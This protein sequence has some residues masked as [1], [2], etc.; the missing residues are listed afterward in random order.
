MRDPWSILGIPKGSSQEEIKKTYRKLARKWHPD[1]NKDPLA[2]E[3]FKEINGAYTRL[4]DSVEE[5]DILL[6]MTAEFLASLFWK[7][8]PRR[9]KKE[10]R[11]VHVTLEEIYRGVE[12][13]IEDGTRISIPRNVE[14]YE[15]IMKGSNMVI[16]VV[17]LEHPVWTREDNDIHCTVKFSLKEA[18][19]GKRFSVRLL[20]GEE[21]CID[22]GGP[23]DLSAPM[24]LK[25]RGLG[26]D[27]MIFRELVWP[28]ELTVNQKMV[29]LNHF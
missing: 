17:T 4:V 13:E 21:M 23:V 28:R 14:N 5:E 8:V 15:K 11:E 9:S 22:D 16:Q 12:R 19:L 3:R 1:K 25:G 20:C 7:P 27:A 18:L 24:L 26:G 6:N 2:G 29:I 10:F